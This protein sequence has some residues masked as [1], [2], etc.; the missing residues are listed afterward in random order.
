MPYSQKI[1]WFAGIPFNC[2]IKIAKIFPCACTYGGDPL[3]GAKLPNLM[4]ANVSGYMA[5]LQ[6]NLAPLIF[7]HPFPE[8]D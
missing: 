2:Q 6:Q 3:F 1:W 7:K 4:T 8:L 5:F